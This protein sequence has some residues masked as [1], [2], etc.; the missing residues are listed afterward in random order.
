MADSP[1]ADPAT[2]ASVSLQPLMQREYSA[3]K[4][5]LRIAG[6]VQFGALL[7]AIVPL[8]HK[9]P[10]TVVAA[11]IAAL[12]VPILI[13]L[14]RGASSPHHVRGEQ[15]RRLLLVQDG[16]GHEPPRAELADLVATGTNLHSLDPKPIGPYFSSKAPIGNRRLVENLQESAFYTKGNA[17]LAARIYRMAAVVGLLLVAGLIYYWLN[18]YFGARDSGATDYAQIYSTLVTFFVAGYLAESSQAFA[19]LRNEAE[20][21]YQQAEALQL[22]SAAPDTHDAYALLLRYSCAT[23]R[24]APLP[25]LVYR[26]TRNRLDAAWRNIFLARERQRT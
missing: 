10:V 16:W 12:G 8:V 6:L 9:T 25:G 11:A 4:L 22:S 26:R 2:A 7:V 21:V 23:T 3:A 5:W 19:E 18:S 13:F 17:A 20:Y 15:L 1:N 24:A 14:L